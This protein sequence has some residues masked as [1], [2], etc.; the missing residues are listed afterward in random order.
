MNK[1]FLEPISRLPKADIPIQGLEAFLSQGAKHQILFMEFSQDVFLPE[2][3]HE[4]QWGVI[5]EGKIELTIAGTNHVFVKGDRYFIPKGIK[6]SARIYAGYADMTFFDQFDRY[7]E[8]K[9][10]RMV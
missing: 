3:S 2:H 1:I 5:L 7:Q 10:E 8:M 6:H 9:N 4:R